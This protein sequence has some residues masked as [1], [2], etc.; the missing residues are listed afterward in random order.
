MV[1]VQE[2]LID[3]FIFSKI[4]EVIWELKKEIL[5]ESKH[6]GLFVIL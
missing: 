3:Y 2:L 4:H 5:V 6:F 1:D